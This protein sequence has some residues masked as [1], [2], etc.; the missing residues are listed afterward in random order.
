MLLAQ[1]T[2]T[3]TVAQHSSFREQL[4]T[5]TD[6]RAALHAPLTAAIAQ[7]VDALGIACLTAAP[8]AAVYRVRMYAKVLLAYGRTVLSSPFVA[9]LFTQNLY[10]SLIT[11]GGNA[12]RNAFRTAKTSI[13]SCV[14]APPTGVR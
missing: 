12:A 11:F 2:T 14:I 1:T 3:P 5:A 6:R 8:I 13:T 10:K 4:G 9:E 7:V